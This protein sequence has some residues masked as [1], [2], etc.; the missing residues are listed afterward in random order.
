MNGDTL[1]QQNDE[2][3]VKF[4]TQ[5]AFVSQDI[6][7]NLAL[8]DFSPETDIEFLEEIEILGPDP[9]TGK[10]RVEIVLD[11]ILA[12]LYEAAEFLQGVLLRMGLSG[13]IAVMLTNDSIH[14]NIM[15]AEPGLIIGHRGQNLDALQHLVNR[16]VNRNSEDLVPVTVDSDDYRQRR[17]QQIERMVATIGKEVLDSGNSV[18]TDPLTPSERRLFHIAAGKFKKIH[19]SSLGDGFFQ[20]IKVSLAH[21][22]QA[23][24]LYNEQL[25]TH[26]ND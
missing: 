11:S 25:H 10:P 20:P 15:G 21:G 2:M 26:E 22:A 16:I 3:N 19:T 8:T 7:Q 23:N 24:Q 13:R 1:E 14:M 4:N 12:R 17:Q 18:I 6:E 9:D 5:D